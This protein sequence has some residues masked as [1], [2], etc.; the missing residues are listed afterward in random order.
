MIKKV[1]D[2]LGIEGVKVSLDVEDTFDLHDGILTGS[3]TISS[4]S[5][6]EVE[7]VKLIFKEKYSRGRRKSKLI[8]EY[9]LG[10]ETI[11]I[12]QKIDKDTLIT[13]RFELPFE[14]LKSSMD[15]F[16]DKNFVYRGISSFAKLIKNA[17]SKYYLVIEASV[18]GN[19][20]KPYDK[21]ELA[22]D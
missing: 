8:D 9:V 10:E 13:Q 2:W 19:K 12:S 7:D 17:K 3:F 15:R 18:K 20:L 16:G 22:A 6:Q 5:D 14:T 11:A 21:I 4:Q 1:K